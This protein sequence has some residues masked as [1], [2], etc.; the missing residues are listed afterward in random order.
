[1]TSR[2]RKGILAI[3]ISSFVKW[4]MGKRGSW[5]LRRKGT[6]GLQRYTSGTHSPANRVSRLCFKKILF[7]FFAHAMLSV[8]VL[9]WIGALE[10]MDVKKSRRVRTVGL[11]SI[12][13]LG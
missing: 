11:V 2:E 12:C 5:K 9:I 8:R 10:G 13:Y 1:M 7:S 6:K 3:S 4:G